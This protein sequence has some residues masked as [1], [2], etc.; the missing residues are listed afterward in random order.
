MYCIQYIIQYSEFQTMG[1]LCPKICFRSTNVVL[2]YRVLYR[3]IAGTAM[4]L[5]IIFYVYHIIT[6]YY[7]NV[8][9]FYC[10]PRTLHVTIK[11]YVKFIANLV[12]IWFKYTLLLLPMKNALSPIAIGLYRKSV[13]QK[14]KFCKFL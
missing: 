12:K 8:L 13:C 14:D 2:Q 3:G 5:K 1:V 9:I 7:D 6:Y 11:L 10:H 4:Q